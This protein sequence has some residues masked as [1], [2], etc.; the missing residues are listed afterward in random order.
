MEWGRRGESFVAGSLASRGWRVLDRNWR[1]GPRE[2]DLVVY[3]DQVL[4]FVEVKTRRCGGKASPALVEE[5]LLSVTP[6]KCRD[7]QKAAQAW[8][9]LLA[10][11]V[12]EGGPL[13]PDLGWPREIRFDVAVVLLEGGR[14]AMTYVADAWRPGW[15]IG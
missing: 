14:Q 4:A 6:R 7:V 15:D 10:R 11:D 5:A 2:L 3:R 8:L 9:R 13:F 1:D 12:T